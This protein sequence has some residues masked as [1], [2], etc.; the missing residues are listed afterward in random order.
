M[1]SELKTKRTFQRKGLK[2]LQMPF[3]SGLSIDKERVAGANSC[4]T[5]QENK[6]CLKSDLL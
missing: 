3:D 2:K 1:H 4:V 5:L 6:Q